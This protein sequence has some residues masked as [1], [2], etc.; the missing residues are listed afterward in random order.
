MDRAIDWLLEK[1]LM[2]I[3]KAVFAFSVI[4]L[5]CL[6]VQQAFNLIQGLCK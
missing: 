1:V 5:G 3:A 4:F 6:F 2:P